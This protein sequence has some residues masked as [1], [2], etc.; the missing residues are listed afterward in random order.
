MMTAMLSLW[1]CGSSRDSSNDTAVF[2]PST[3]DPQALFVGSDACQTCHSSIY[4]D[5]V[6]SGHP[7][8][9]NKVVNNQI[10]TF[11]LSTING[12]LEQVD[13]EDGV[14][15]NSLGTPTSYAD[16]SYVIGGYG[17][18]ARWID[19]DGFI[20]TG[21][22]VQY[23]LEDGSM[24]GYHDDEV[25]KKYNCGNCHTTGWRRYDDSLNPNRQDNLPGM[26]GTFVA[27]GIQCESC[28]GPGAKHV[29]SQN[30]ADIV[31]LAE[32]RTTSEL[33]AGDM[34][35]AKAVACSECHTRDG[36]KDYPSYVSPFNQAFPAGPKN[37][38]RIAAS[39]GFVKHHE[40]YDEMLGVNPDTGA[41]LGKHLAAGVSCSTCHDPHK[42]IKHQDQTGE[43]AIR[44]A[45]T[46]CH[47]AGKQFE[48]A[49]PAGSVMANFDCESCHMPKL[50]KSA[51]K[52]AAVGTGPATG[53]IAT[54]IFR[55]NLEGEQFTAD[56]K[57]ANPWIS[58]DFAC[59]TCHNGVDSFDVS[60]S[61]LSEYTF[62]R[63]SVSQT[64]ATN[65]YAGS[66]TC[67]GC[68][69][70]KYADFSQ[71]GHPFKLNKVTD[72]DGD[73]FND[74]PSY[75]L[76]DITGALEQVSDEDGVTDN[77]LG[78]P[79]D[80]DDV[81]YVIGGYGWKAR[82]IDLDGF[83]VTGSAVQYN[84]EDGSMAGY[85]D[86][87]VDKPYNCGNCHTTGWKHFDATLNPNRQ[88]GL[89]GMDG[90]FA[91]SAIGCE[92]CHGAG[93]RHIFTRNAAEIT[94]NAT[95]RTTAD[96]L[97]ADMA[98]GLPVACGECHTRDGEK[99]YPSFQSAA[100]GAGYTGD[101]GGRIVSNGTIA[102]H[103]EQYDELLGLDIDDTGALTGN[104]PLGK[105][106]LAGLTC[107]TCHDPHKSTKYGVAGAIKID[108]T[109]CHADKVSFTVAS[110]AG[111]DCI[112][113]HMPKLAKS[114]IWTGE[115][116]VNGDFTGLNKAGV[117]VGDIKSHIFEIDL[118]ETEQITSDTKWVFPRITPDYAC[119]TCH[120]DPATRVGNLNLNQGGLIH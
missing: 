20:V 72:V 60:T 119:G 51:V 85:H 64:L 57:F 81:T 99:D 45:C 7:Y 108:C 92:S 17:W 66:A 22:A 111:A 56:G 97:A 90:T 102:K 10:P 83:I 40:Q 109:T 76:S 63:A 116:D 59:G 34:G 42:T 15:D 106:L 52:H 77:S 18:K 101:Q 6:D 118:S 28:H 68:H 5:F 39:G 14:T 84:L 87:E 4:G 26:D 105:H 113:C 49:M 67:G 78:T 110:H 11:P 74:V 29:S 103:H 19:A 1:G 104:G 3:A 25:D 37:G 98:Y 9:L 65:Q 12:A 32:A 35:Y 54:H 30:K 33:L 61:D 46:D 112:S 114:A 73:G 13:D 48:V 94:L 80:Y 82:W 75:P 120:A 89:P 44:K 69:E 36:E 79:L 23:N 93:L 107:A 95:A 55:I 41:P 88:D 71:S 24:A 91:E 2:T 21:S 58:K 96:F 16:V 86:N 38:G 27:G 62:H 43:N 117:K 100:N 53:D 115:K 70:T 31:R 50:A 47:G 8:K